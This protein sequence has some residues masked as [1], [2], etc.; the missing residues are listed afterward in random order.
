VGFAVG[1]GLPVLPV[2]VL[3]PAGWLARTLALPAAEPGVGLPDVFFYWGG[4]PPALALALAAGV[5][6]A[7]LLFLVAKDR[8]ELSTGATIA[9]LS[10][11]FLAGAPPSDL[12]LPLAL[13]AL[14]GLVEG[15]GSPPS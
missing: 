8:L 2:A 14:T 1:Y 5:V 13:L 15:E 12:G 11:V 10:A 7:F 4:S 6:T 9:A 3:D